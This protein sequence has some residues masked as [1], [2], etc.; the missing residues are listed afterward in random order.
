MLFCS[1][2]EANEVSFYYLF[3]IWNYIEI[4]GIR[5]KTN[6]VLLLYGYIISLKVI[7][8]WWEV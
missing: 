8:I 3:N 6:W 2:T 4:I 1:T 5:K 7:I